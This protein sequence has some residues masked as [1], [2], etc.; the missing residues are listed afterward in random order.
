MLNK[1]KKT[2]SAGSSEIKNIHLFYSPLT[3]LFLLATGLTIILFFN[4]QI[5]Y[6][7]HL[8]RIKHIENIVPSSN[9][10]Q[11]AI[12]LLENAEYKQTEN[13]EQA[14]LK[15]KRSLLYIP[16]TVTRGLEMSVILNNL[17]LE[18]AQ[19]NS[20]FRNYRHSVFFL[21]KEIQNLQSKRPKAT[22]LIQ[23]LQ[24]LQQQLQSL[25]AVESNALEKQAHIVA[26]IQTLTNT[27]QPSSIKELLKHATLIL[28][29]HQQLY[30]F[31]QQFQHFNLS[32]KSNV[33]LTHYNRDFLKKIYRVHRLKQWFS[34]VFFGLLIVVFISLYRLVTRV[35]FLENNSRKLQQI[36]D[37]AP[38]M[39]WM[40]D[41]V[42]NLIFTNDYWEKTFSFYNQRNIYSTKYLELIHPD[43][44]QAVLYF[45]QQ[46][47]DN[48]KVSG[49][50]FRVKNK[51]GNYI[52][53]H[54]N[55]V[56]RFS[57]HGEHLGFIC[58]I[59]DISHQKKLE[60]DVKL[61]ASVFENSIEG[62]CLTNAQHEIVQVNRAFEKLIG[63][64]QKDVI[65]KKADIMRSGLETSEL[66]EAMEKG[67]REKGTWQGEIYSRRK[68]GEIFPEWLIMTIIKNNKEERTH[69]IAV[70][71]DLTE[72]KKAEEDIKYLANYDSIT[73]VFN[74]KMFNT[75]VDHA[76]NQ[77]RR[78]QM[79]VAILFLSLGRFKAVNDTLGHEAGNQLLALVAEDLKNCV[80]DVDTVARVGG[81]EFAIFIDGV[82]NKDVYNQCTD[83]I[84]AIIEHLSSAYVINNKKVFIGVTI[85]I[86]IFPDDADSVEILIKHADMAMHHAKSTQHN[87]FAFYSTNLNKRIQKR[88]HL[89]LELREALERNQLFLHYQPQYNLKTKQIEGFEALIR[90]QHPELGFIPPDEFIGIA[91]ET[92]LIIEIGKWVLE[93]ACKQLVIWQQ[94]NS[95]PLRMAVNVSL[96]QL[97]REGFVEYVEQIL[98][99]MKLPAIMLEIEVTESM[100]LDEDSF[101]LK[102]LHCLNDLGVQIS[103]D[104]FGTGYSNMAYLK[105][106]PINRIK[107]D[108]CFVSGIPEDKDGAAI[109]GVIIDI[110][111]HFEI[112]VIAEG[113]E[114]QEQADY[115]LAQGCD[116]GQ[117]YLFSRPV[118]AAEIEKLLI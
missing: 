87:D 7:A 64:S 74:R 2:I 104:D 65:G 22:F 92:G 108:R 25:S 99:Q 13:V 8:K 94:K 33:L 67:F 57:E 23:E 31:N 55:L 77:A 35:Y 69:Y 3:L 48:P 110:A 63:Y 26:L 30:K 38:V 88:L 105:K 5:D 1:I 4:S 6:P 106:L 84:E 29:Y 79:C 40:S 27:T 9:A 62:I 41:S 115:L 70:F 56:T 111:R 102:L 112:K 47:I 19:I 80:R 58:S 95:T 90:W 101:S 21:P 32:H 49:V 82:A 75:I 53:L 71:R 20:N 45:Y 36:A 61:A 39:L 12:L 43:D 103:M 85:G 81:D 28:G 93:T 98:R 11:E 37:Y 100:F 83:T 18:S 117:G 10:L 113:I 68:N 54:E 17:L 60:E 50:Q 86:S 59:I 109:V 42:G 89:E 66:Y 118:P 44:R 51:C 15:L 52:Y 46:Q 16:D 78:N 91:E 34:L 96:K 24:L 107:I 114:E 76:L 116:E 72:Q 14:E 97:E 73:K